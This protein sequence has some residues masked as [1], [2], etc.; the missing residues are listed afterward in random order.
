MLGVLYREGWMWPVLARYCS[1]MSFLLVLVLLC[2]DRALRWFPPSS[3]CSHLTSTSGRSST[4]LDC[5]S[6]HFL[7]V[8]KLAIN[9]SGLVSLER[10]TL[11]C[12]PNCAPNSAW[13]C[14]SPCLS[15]PIYKMR[16]RSLL[17]AFQ[18]QSPS[19]PWAPRSGSRVPHGRSVRTRLVRREAQALPLAGLTHS[20]TPASVLQGIFLARLCWCLTSTWSTSTTLLT[21]SASPPTT[22]PPTAQCWVRR[23]I[24][25][26]ITTTPRCWMGPCWIPRKGSRMVGEWAWSCVPTVRLS[27]ATGWQL[28]LHTFPTAE[29]QPTP[30]HGALFWVPHEYSPPA[31]VKLSL[32]KQTS[33]LLSLKIYLQMK[34]RLWGLAIRSLSAVLLHC[35]RVLLGPISCLPG[36]HVQWCRMCTAYSLLASFCHG[37]NVF[38]FSQNLSLIPRKNQLLPLL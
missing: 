16:G 30:P 26:S 9:C 3:W 31:P 4:A 15:F 27:S 17:P 25:S 7:T 14:T 29:S 38:P 6:F 21:P 35:F 11:N 12:S 5:L 37:L 18:L 33:Q 8:M 34:S 24:T 20:L 22:S 13:P 36:S 19:V 32:W 10:I 28:Y 2:S 23:G 1:P